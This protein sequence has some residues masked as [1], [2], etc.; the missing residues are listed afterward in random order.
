MH[1]YKEN[2]FALLLIGYVLAQYIFF[3][4]RGIN[5]R[6][7]QGTGVRTGLLQRLSVLSDARYTAN[8]LGTVNPLSGGMWCGLLASSN[9]STP[10]T[11]WPGHGSKLAE[12]DA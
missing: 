10:P 4:R 3:L 9:S 12:L 6:L 8:P 11:G 2:L 1:S 5:Y 7:P